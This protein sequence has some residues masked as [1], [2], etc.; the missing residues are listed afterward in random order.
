MTDTLHHYFSFNLL[1]I[2]AVRR[3]ACLPAGPPTDFWDVEGTR[4]AGH[5]SPARFGASHA[6]QEVL[7]LIVLA[8]AGAAERLGRGW[9]A[10]FR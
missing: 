1:K 2:S 9:R 5:A 7:G 10:Y 3:A 8:V 4:R 6:R